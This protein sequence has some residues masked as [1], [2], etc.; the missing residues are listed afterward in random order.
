MPEW[1]LHG[2]TLLLTLVSLA[3]GYKGVSIQMKE[4]QERN[5][6]ER[7]RQHRE[8]T[9]TLSLMQQ[10]IAIIKTELRPIANWWNGG[11]ASGGRS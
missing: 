7:E 1:V 4:W 2:A 8:N 9:T 6:A 3:M 11:P 10:D 5:V